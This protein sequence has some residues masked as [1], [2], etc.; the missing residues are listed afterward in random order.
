MFKQTQVRF[1][2]L[3]VLIA[4]SLGTVQGMRIGHGALPSPNDI[5]KWKKLLELYSNAQERIHRQSKST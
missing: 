1:Y 3:I 4:V 2:L 5:D